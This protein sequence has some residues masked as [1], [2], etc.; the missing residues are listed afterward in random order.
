[1][2]FDALKGLLSQS[3]VMNEG[4]LRQMKNPYARLSSVL[5]GV[6]TIA[7]TQSALSQVALSKEQLESEFYRIKGDQAAIAEIYRQ[8]EVNGTYNYKDFLNNGGPAF[9]R[10]ALIGNL[11]TVVYTITQNDADFPTRPIRQGH[12]YKKRG[13]QLLSR[14]SLQLCRR[15][16]RA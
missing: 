15:C 8:V 7:Q 1:M 3:T 4:Q 10:K 6:G 2:A 12:W 5:G 13:T 11:N 16:S 14:C 9:H